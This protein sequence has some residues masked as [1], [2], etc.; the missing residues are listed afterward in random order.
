[1]TSQQSVP[2]LAQD[3]SVP[4]IYL[5]SPLTNLSNEERRCLGSEISL[6][7]VLI[8]QLTVGDRVEGEVW[9]VGVYA[10]IDHTAPWKGDSLSPSQVYERNLTE[11]LDSDALIVLADRAASAGVGQEI[12]WAARSG[13]PILYLSSAASV[14]RQ[15]AGI[16][17]F[18]TCVP[19]NHDSATLAAHVDNFVRKWRAFIQDAPRRRASRRLRF[20][21]LVS[22]L[23]AAWTTANDPTGISARCGLHPNFI[24]MALADPARVAFMP[25]DMISMLCAELGV[26]LHGPSNQLSIRATRALILTAIEDSWSDET[27]ARMRIYGLAATAREPAT[28]LDTL[29]AWRNLH[30]LVS[31]N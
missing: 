21:P 15:I 6:V 24:H 10:P 27:I 23:R 5:A 8:E 28:D 13:I 4:R 18:I 19:Y 11:L 22:R 31:S 26:R 17:A 25:I 7:K 12:E 3:Y 9:P 16:P 14:S 1:M 29:D 30:S 2:V 20:E